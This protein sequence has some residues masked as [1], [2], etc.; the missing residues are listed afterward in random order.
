LKAN[1]KDTFA[2]HYL[3]EAYQLLEAALGQ[4]GDH[5][6]AAQAADALTGLLPGEP[7]AT[8]HSARMLGASASLAA[9][10]VDLPEARRKALAESR[11]ALA[12]KRLQK[13]VKEGAKI[14]PQELDG[15]EFKTIRAHFPEPFE[16]LKKTLEARRADPKVG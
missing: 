3:I 14:L 8:F 15:P 2:Q 11:A 13:A 10:A 6:G 7:I 4:L 16:A 5:A 1:P 12:L 9:A